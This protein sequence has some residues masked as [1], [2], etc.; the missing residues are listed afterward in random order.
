MSRKRNYE[1]PVYKNFRNAVLKRDN[2]TC[3]MCNRKGK[4]IWLN[5]HHIIKWSSASSLRYDVDNGISLCRD[6]HKEVTG[7]ESHYI[8]YLT[9]K[10]RRNKK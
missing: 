5:V 10:V 4:G 8:T 3:Q 2:F 9:E 7:K 1:C 6:C